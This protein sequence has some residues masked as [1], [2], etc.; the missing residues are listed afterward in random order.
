MNRTIALFAFLLALSGCEKKA[1]NAAAGAAGSEVLPGSV[2]DA[3]LD[4][5]QSRAQAPVV[6]AKPTGNKTPAGEEAPLANRGVPPL[7]DTPASSATSGTKS[8]TAPN[9]SATL[10]PQ[11]STG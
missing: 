5:N 3:M 9:A 8:V 11:P 7:E 1:E 4:T 2:S 6:A 10:N